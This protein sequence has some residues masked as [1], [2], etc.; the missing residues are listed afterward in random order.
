MCTAYGK[1][2]L[3]MLISVSVLAII[4]PSSTDG[5]DCRDFTVRMRA[6]T[7]SESTKLDIELVYKYDRLWNP[8]QRGSSQKL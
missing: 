7:G 2:I 4:F 8:S 1:L 6:V 3:S 5:Q